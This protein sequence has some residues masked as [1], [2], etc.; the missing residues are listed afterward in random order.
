MRL[1]VAMIAA[2]IDLLLLP[3]GDTC[4]YSICNWGFKNS[5]DFYFHTLSI[6]GSNN[7][8]IINSKLQFQW[9][10]TYSL[11]RIIWFIALRHVFCDK[12]NLIIKIKRYDDDDDDNDNDDDNDYNDRTKSKTMSMLLSPFCTQHVRRSQKHKLKRVVVV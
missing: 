2:M 8:L 9:L 3:Y 11:D 7:F 1:L 12:T 10:N 6:V 4:K 5:H